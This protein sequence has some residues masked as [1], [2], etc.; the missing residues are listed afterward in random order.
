MKNVRGFTLVEVMVTLV[1]LAIVLS[2][3]V[4]SFNTLLQDN[5]MTTRANDVVIA[6]NL[7]RSEAI[8]RGADAT[9]TA[10]GGDWNNGWTVAAGGADLRIFP[11]TAGT[12]TITGS[13]PAITYRGSGMATQLTVTVCDSGRTGE[14]GRQITVAATGRLAMGNFVCD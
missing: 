7:A 4:P 5:R 3:A 8:K 9:V 13:I 14:T 10:T 11:A 1:V 2:F 6:L 12:V